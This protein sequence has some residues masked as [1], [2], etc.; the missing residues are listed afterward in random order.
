MV[1]IINDSNEKR[2][3]EE[4]TLFFEWYQCNIT[5]PKETLFIEVNEEIYLRKWKEEWNELE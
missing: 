2:I 4:H 5:P 1:D 3:I